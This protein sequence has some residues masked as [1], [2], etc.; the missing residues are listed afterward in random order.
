MV[1]YELSDLIL[2]AEDVK[3]VISKLKKNKATGPDKIHNKLL[4]AAVNIISEP[5][6]SYF[7]RCLTEGKFP[8]AWKLAYVTPIFKKG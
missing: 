7:N 4:I 2:T 8:S 1:E 5:L 3:L 6:A